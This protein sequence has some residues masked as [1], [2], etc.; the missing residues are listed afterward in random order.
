MLSVTQPALKMACRPASM[1]VLIVSVLK[2]LQ[3]LDQNN[4]SYSQKLYPPMNGINVLT[5]P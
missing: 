3:D 4:F 5:L 1:P 2:R